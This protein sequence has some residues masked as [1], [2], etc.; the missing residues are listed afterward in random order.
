[1]DL[2][3]LSAIYTE[4]NICAIYIYCTQCVCIYTCIYIYAI[5]IYHTQYKREILLS[6]NL[7]P[8]GYQSNYFSCCYCCQLDKKV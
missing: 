3:I 1:M 2:F 8:F 7:L 6:F 4:F 5:Y